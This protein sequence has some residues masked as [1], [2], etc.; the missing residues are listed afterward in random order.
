MPATMYY[1]RAYAINA[2][3]I[4][5]GKSIPLATGYIGDGQSAI[6]KTGDNEG[7][8]IPLFLCMAAVTSGVWVMLCRKKA[9]IMES[10]NVNSLRIRMK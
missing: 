9:V 5:Y 1:V 2:A 7:I 4:S 3:G 10:R 6:P 8:V